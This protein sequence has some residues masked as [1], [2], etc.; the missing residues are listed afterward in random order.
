M[1]ERSILVIDD[2]DD[3]VAFVTAVLE[4][5][6]TEVFSARD[7]VAGLEAAK[8]RLPDLIILDV[9]MPKKDGFTVFSEL[10]EDEATRNIPVI[11]L[12]GVGE[13]TGVSFS[14][15]DMG[16]FIGTEPEAYVEKPID[17]ETLQSCVEQILGK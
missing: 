4:E 12:T 14:K 10:K 16:D 7:G 8:T 9:Q 13:K 2:E 15:G 5:E 11:M 3:C 1:A 6:G 17:P